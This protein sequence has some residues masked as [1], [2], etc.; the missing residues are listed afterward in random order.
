M[1]LGRRSRSRTSKSLTQSQ[2]VSSKYLTEKINEAI[3]ALKK[4]YDAEINALK[5]ELG[6]VK[7]S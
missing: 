7:E 2:E 1:S 3:D 6:V 5:A 4:V